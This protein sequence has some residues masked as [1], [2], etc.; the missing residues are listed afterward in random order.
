MTKISKSPE[1]HTFQAENYVKRCEE[2]GTTPNE[3]YL[4]LYKSARQQ[5]EE[6]MVDPKWQKDNMEY[7]LRSTEW[8]LEKTRGDDVY[9][10][11]LYAAMCNNEFVKREM[12]PILKDQRWSCSW[13]HAGGIVADMRQEGDYIDWYCSGIRNDGYQDD[14]NDTTELTIEQESFRKKAAAYVPESLVT[15]EIESDLYRLGW[16]VVKYDNSKDI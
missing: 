8:I 2:E 13:R 3:D 9:A 15:E 16:L 12:W 14:P 7:D 1:R 6:N 4:D 5:D 11:N 10:Q